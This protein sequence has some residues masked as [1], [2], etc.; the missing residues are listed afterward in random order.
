MAGIEADIDD[1]EYNADTFGTYRA[2]L[3]DMQTA[4]VEW[5]LI[6]NGKFCMSPTVSVSTFSQTSIIAGK[7]KYIPF[8]KKA[9]KFRNGYN[10]VNFNTCCWYYFK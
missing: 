3:K 9:Y 1:M 2:N 4:V 6:G 5:S 8:D 10:C 7:C